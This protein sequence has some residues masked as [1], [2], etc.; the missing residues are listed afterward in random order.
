ME[1][2]KTLDRSSIILK[3]GTFDDRHTGDIISEKFNTMLSEWN[4]TKE[5]VQCLIRDEGSN[6]KRA[7]RLAALNDV[8]CTV[9]KIQLAIRSCL[10]SQENIKM[11]KQKCKKI[12]T[13]LN[14]STIAQNNC[15]QFKKD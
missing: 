2:Q 15:K 4:I 7:G 6:M 13:H 9:H 1:L 3:C 5:Q 11:I 12:S 10:G 14:H 8:D